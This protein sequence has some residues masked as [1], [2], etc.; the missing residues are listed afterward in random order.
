LFL[1]IG[2]DPPEEPVQQ[3]GYHQGKI[4][5][6]SEVLMAGSLEEA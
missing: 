5:G 3:I 2:P 1:F 4:A 6:L